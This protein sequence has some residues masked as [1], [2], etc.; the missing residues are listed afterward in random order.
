MIKNTFEQTPDYVLSAY[1]DNA[2]VMEGSTVG[3]WFPDQ[4]GQY[5][6]HQEDA[7]ILMKVE[8][9]NHP[10]AIS[11][12]PG[13]ATGSGGE[14]R[15]EGATGR[16]AKPKAGLTGFSVSNLVIPDFK[17]PWENDLSKPNR[18]ASALDIMIEGPLGGAA[19]NNE[20]GRPALLG[21]FRTYEEK[22]N[23]FAGEEVRGY[24]KPI[25]LAGGIGNIHAEHV[26]KGEIPVGAKLVVLGGP[27]MNIGLGGGAASSMASG[28][29]KEDLDFASVQ[30]EN[31]EMERRCQEVIDRCWQLGEENPIAFIHDV[32]AGGLSNAMPELVHDGDR[33][34][35]FD[36]RS[37]LCDEKGMSPL[38]IWCN[39][40]QERY[41]LAVSAD[42]LAQFEEI[43]RRE[44]A[45]YAVIGEA[46]KEKHLTLHDN[47][48]DNNPIDLPM[49]VLLGKT[50]KMHR[51]VSS[52]TVENQPLDQQGIQLKEALHRV[53][54]LPVVAEKTFLI[55]IGDRSVTGM[56]ARDQMVGPWQI[57]VSDVAITTASLDSYHGEAMTMGERAPVALLDFGASARLAVAESITNIAATNIGDI[58]RIK[59]SANWMSAAGHTG[60]D[61]GLY[62][63]VK[64]VGEELCPALGLTIP[65][66][67]DSMSMR[68]T[69]EENGEQK[70]VTAPLSLVIS[71]FAR[72][73]DVRKTITPQLRTDKGLS[74]LLLIDLG[75]G[76]NR[77]GATALAQVYKQL[78][79]K[80]ADVVNVQR[81][82][83]FYNAMQALVA[84]DQL[85][86]YHDRSDGGLITT[87]AEMAFAGHCGVEVDISALGDNDLAVLFN[88]E[89][90]AVIQVADSQLESVREVLKAHNL[91]GITHELGAVTADDRFEISRSSRKLLSEKRSELRGIWAELTHQM[92]RLRDNPECADQEF[93][94]KKNPAD[95]GL[96]AFLTYDVNEDIAAPFI[97]KGTKPTIAILREQ[98]VN[99]HYEMAAA[100]D[101][102]GFNA[103]DVHMSD[104]MASRRN[105][106]DFNALVACGGFSYGDVLGAGGGW[107][108]SILF[109]PQLRDQFSQFFE[110]P[111]TLALGVC[112]GC[113][114]VSNLAEIIPGTENWPRFVRNKSERFEARV[115]L[116]KINE[117][118]SPWFA[119]MAGSHMP[120]AV[121]HGEGQVEFNSAEQLAGLKAQGLIAAQYIDNNG[122][123]TEVYPANPNGSVEGITAITNVDGRVAIMMPHPERVFRAVSNSWYPED[124]TEDGAWMR[125]FRNV[126]VALK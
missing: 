103:I 97:N 16:G 91:L 101:R 37:I 83:D 4:D 18:I 105:L 89:L 27:A 67:K 70:A 78:G 115:G 30:R 118:A 7:H 36:L 20:F 2:A 50:P 12:F 98:G 82:K 11:P 120:I 111:N 113:Q 56:V 23:S 49:N 62:E 72:V 63:A 99:S 66:G 68:T 87:L 109:N 86:A 95:K 39:E 85:L 52:K 14:I 123:S 73:E 34:G 29:S 46:T 21:Y 96:S 60:E 53:L 65:V 33:G 19:F 48:F 64:A 110:N 15:D 44:R 5:R 58:K 77:L 1:K 75:E 22:V 38:E 59:L 106:A 9:H 10:T 55:T 61:A 54:R 6:A 69:W 102:A 116:V 104:L 35:K 107:A 79:D 28:K 45:P 13:A 88:E 25:M 8:T 114:M 100:F 108:K 117:V 41:V 74:S 126:R 71:A 32:G 90:G 125:L 93:E 119:G 92:Q 124:W 40:S 51:E 31:P 26:Q 43:C 84:E 81:L 122:N 3:R 94:A 57:P 47:H 112:N 24:H 121:S 76:K 80:P 17:Q 42:K